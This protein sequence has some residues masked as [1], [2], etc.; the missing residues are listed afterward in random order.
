M[1]K[2]YFSKLIAITKSLIAVLTCLCLTACGF[3]LRHQPPL[4]PSLQTLYLQ[5]SDPYGQFE[6]ML[7]QTLK[8]AGVTLVSNPNQAPFILNI[9]SKN[10]STT[11]VSIGT[12]S[13]ARVYSLTYE[14]TYAL[15]N[16][17]GKTLVGP[18][19]VSASGSLTLNP[20]QLLESNGQQDQMIMQLQRQDIQQIIAQL[21]SKQVAQTVGNSPSL[22]ATPPHP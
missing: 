7:K 6:S 11:D 12:S 15:S 19:T 22:P 5:S 17:Q 4:P 13:Q 2:T 20:N 3:E 14:V 1:Q 18:R 8:L 21:G 16:Q 9:Q 10:F